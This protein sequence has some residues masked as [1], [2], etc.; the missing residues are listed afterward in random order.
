[1]LRGPRR[2]KRRARRTMQETNKWRTSSDREERCASTILDNPVNKTESITEMAHFSF[3]SWRKHCVMRREN[4]EDSRRTTA[5]ER[6]VPAH[7]VD[8]VFMGDERDGST[9]ALL[10]A[11][12]GIPEAVFSGVVPW[13][14]T[15]Q[16]VCGRPMAA[17]RDRT[18]ARGLHR[19]V[20]Q[21]SRTH[22][23]GRVMDRF[24]SDEVRYDCRTQASG[25]LPQQRHRGRGRFNQFMGMIRTI[26]ISLEEWW[27]SDNWYRALHLAVDRRPRRI[28]VVEVGQYR[29]A[30]PALHHSDWHTARHTRWFLGT[31]RKM[32]TTSSYGSHFA[33][34]KSLRTCLVLLGTIRPTL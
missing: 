8:S 33:L 30:H 19:K 9:L 15:A 12:A 26:S 22:E 34:E 29:K 28:L 24:A 32:T 25:H 21:R 6:N 23:F 10:S 18:G 2:R 5:E 13:T 7:H 31:V 4:E 17:S 16:R 1:M 14:T 27:G 11:G 20:T 3:R